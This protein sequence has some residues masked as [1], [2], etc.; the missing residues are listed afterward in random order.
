VVDDGDVE[1]FRWRP[2]RDR[3]AQHVG[4]ARIARAVAGRVEQIVSTAAAPC[5]RR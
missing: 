4:I 5:P 2:D 3:R 1:G